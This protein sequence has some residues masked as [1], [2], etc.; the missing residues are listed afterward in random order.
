MQIFTETAGDQQVTQTRQYV[1]KEKKDN[2]R[3]RDI[4]VSGEL[5]T[6][7]ILSKV[8]VEVLQGGFPSLPERVAVPRQ[9]MCC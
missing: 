5:E 3:R 7:S 8:R 6:T 9:L 2:E 1:E 4:I